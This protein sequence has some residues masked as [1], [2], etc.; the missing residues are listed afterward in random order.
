MSP[1]LVSR[2][3]G[4]KDVAD[5]QHDEVDRDHREEGREHLD[6]EQAQHPHAASP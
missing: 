5:A 2:P 1:T 4:G 3:I 6:E